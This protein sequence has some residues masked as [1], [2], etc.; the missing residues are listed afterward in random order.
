MDRSKSEENCDAHTMHTESLKS[1]V[2]SSKHKGAGMRGIQKIKN[3]DGSNCYRA[4]VRLNDGISQQSKSFPSLV[5]AR[6]WKAHEETKRR[7]GMYFPSMTS[8]QDIRDVELIL[9]KISNN[10][11]Q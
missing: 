4:Q 8:K 1:T 2:R 11:G 7:H 3:K 9:I 6:T 5:Q 10:T